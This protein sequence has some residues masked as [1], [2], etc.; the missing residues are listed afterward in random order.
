MTFVW[1]YNLLN[2]FSPSL[3]LR[4]KCLSVMLQYPSLR[5][6]F[7]RPATPLIQSY[8]SLCA[9]ITFLQQPNVFIGFFQHPPLRTADAYLCSGS[10]QSYRVFYLS[11]SALFPKPQIIGKKGGNRRENNESFSHKFISWVFKESIMKMK[12]LNLTQA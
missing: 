5:V 12:T 6:L 7:R 10:L 1:R 9:Q 8:L 3:G 2:V 4:D 11:S